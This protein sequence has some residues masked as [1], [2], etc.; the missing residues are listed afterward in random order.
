MQR[1]L[2][3][4]LAARFGDG[5]RQVGDQH[6]FVEGEVGGVRVFAGAD[7]ADHRRGDG[8]DGAGALVD[9]HD[10]HAVVKLVQCHRFSCCPDGAF[11]A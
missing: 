9:F 1:L 7:H 11:F 2:E 4:A 8:A 6:G 5:N 10:A 3:V